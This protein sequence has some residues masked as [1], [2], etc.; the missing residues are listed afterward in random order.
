MLSKYETQ[1]AFVQAVAARLPA[2]EVPVD[3]VRAVVGGIVAADEALQ[4]ETEGDG[5]SELQLRLGRWFLRDDDTPY[6]ESAGMIAGIT[7]SL[8]AT[9][10]VPLA[11]AVAAATTLGAATWRV[12]RKG[13]RLSPDQMA[14]LTALDTQGPLNEEQL[15]AVLAPG[16]RPMQI[17]HLRA[18]L[19]QL[20]DVE[21]RDGSSATLV[22]RSDDARWR[23]V[24]V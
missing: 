11:A 12:W 2:D 19:R 3:V 14:V 17:D 6:F 8:I 24:G 4:R 5:W 20:G 15:H 21:L 9:G 10:A 7:A 22:R 16:P 1:D 23:V 18:V 13:G